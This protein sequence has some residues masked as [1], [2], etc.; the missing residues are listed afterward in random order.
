[1]KKPFYLTTPLYYVNAAPHIGHSYTT[2]ASDCLARYHRLKGE[3]VFFLTGTDEHG[4]KIAR[5][6]KQ[7]GTS[8][9]EFVDKNSEKFKKLWKTL[10]ISYD[11][12][13]RTTDASHREVVKR[14]LN[15]LRPTLIEGTFSSWYCVPCETS[16]GTSEVDASHPL[17]LNCKRPLEQVEE[18]DFSLHL[19]D[20]RRWLKEYMLGHEEFILPPERRNE[21]LSLLENELPDLCITRPKERVEW[22]IA[23]PFSDRH[24]AYVWFDALLNYISALGWPE[25]ERFPRYWK[26]AGAVHIVGKDILRH[27]AIYWPIALHVLGIPPPQTI[28][29][30]GWWK[31]GEEKMSKSKGNVIDPLDMVSKYGVDPYRYFLLRE[32]PFGQDGVFSEEALVTRLNNDLANDLGNLV[33]RALTM[34]EKYFEG[35]VP[36][37][38]KTKDLE[39][40]ALL[41]TVDQKMERFQFDGA[42][43]AIWELIRRANQF[44]EEKAPWKIA[45]AKDTQT[46]SS[47]LYELLETLKGV[48]LFIYPFI[49]ST[50]ESI[51]NQIGIS[52]KISSASYE[53]LGKPLVLAGTKIRKGEI[54]YQKVER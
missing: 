27:H 26:E 47:V 18:V 15:A 17:C 5:A 36:E 45:K 35:K 39:S 34:V 7:S 8:P 40:E 21:M 54:L 11:F 37:A 1:M 29:A 31:V 41:E 12:F 28:F 19:E 48:S 49:P 46:L 24:V 53:D 25:G 6:A 4:E 10:N 38:K 14:A 32:V 2:I 30:H 3:E 51:W 52:Q 50:A 42:L 33:Y 13:L 20:H 16:F 9:Q 44:I 43:L 22:G 23:V